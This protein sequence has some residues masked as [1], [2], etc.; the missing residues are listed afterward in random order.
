VNR[1]PTKSERQE[2]RIIAW[3]DS[4]RADVVFGWRQLRKRKVTSAA[5]ILSLALGIGACTSAFR[6]IDALF[7]RPLPVANPERLYSLSRQGFQMYGKSSAYDGWDYP[8]FGQMRDAVAKQATLIAISFAERVDLTYNSDQEMEKAHVQNVSGAMFSSFGLRATTG[9][10][11]TENDDLKPGAHPVAV[12]SH[13]YWSRRF[14]QDPKVIGRTFRMGNNLVGVRVYEIV[15]VAGEGFTGTEPGKVIDIFM[16]TMMHW[17]IAYPDWSLFRSFA[18]VKPGISAEPVRDRL[19]AA[20]RAFNEGKA[21]RV[22]KQRAELLKQQLLM[23]PAAAGVSGMQ[24]DYRI[25]LAALGV[26]VALVLLM[27]CANVAN[28]MT[29]Q[30]AARAH[31]MALRV[32]IGAGR[33]RLVQLALV[34]SAMLAFLAAAIGGLFAWRSAPF[35][36]SRINPP[37]N[38]ASLSLP[39]DWR[40]L[41]FCVALTLAVTF[42][43]GL[44]PALRAS[45]VKPVAALKG[46][47]DPY[48][49]GRW[50]RAL[51]AVQAAFCFLVLFIAGL[52]A[53][54]LHRLQN[55]PSG[56]S[57]ERLLN[58]NTVTQKNEPGAV[59]DQ[60]VEHLRSVRG[61]EKVAYADWPLL[62]GY[63]FK[64]NAPSIDGAP[65]GEVAG[66]FLNVSPGWIDVM[67][68]PFVDGRDFRASD[69]SP[70]AA[71]VNESFA[72]QFFGR[73]NPIGK[74]FE[75]TSGYMR[76]QRFE[77]VGVVRDARYRYLRESILPV[78]Y[79]PFNRLGSGGT[80]QGGT[81]I[82]RT[83]TSNP[84][85]LGSIL[86]REITRA[87]PDF[88]V[89]SIRTQKELEQS[90]TVR[91]RLLAMLASFFGVVALM[92]AGVGLYGV[93][94]YSVLQRRREIGIRM[95]LGAQGSDVVRRVTL[96]VVIMVLAGALVGLATG[97][98]SA[99]YIETLLYQ[100]KTTEV[101]ILVFPSVAISAVALLAALPALIR[102]VRIDPVTVLR[103]E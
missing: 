90:Q 63:G 100:V 27:A 75:G 16:P 44:I 92:L 74:W 69:L 64:M 11:L 94:D 34:E 65:P 82:V 49:R 24:K 20:L 72:K 38:P 13:D 19:N 39:A 23:E 17:G 8:L 52:F 29:A 42:L 15:G 43:F 95:A 78:A 6:L 32:S 50:M 70:G 46:G 76:G 83:S 54:T 59:W 71:I 12:L 87:R 31:E 7:L 91:E 99:R 9:R 22:P 62:D 79:T 18:H 68:I 80:M 66:W 4:L 10:L 56:F 53:A 1:V 48:Y 88:R 93:L 67:K 86:R 14:G 40:V 25:S 57:S 96:D 55:Q 37:D 73:E 85:A 103:A 33:W 81:F 97:M 26:F 60:V 89:S 21:N 101:G 5:A 47:D 45:A 102:A 51:I 35:V 28:L 36:V 98:A 3:L 58:L 2:T 41:G 84:L 77:I 30:A 61:V